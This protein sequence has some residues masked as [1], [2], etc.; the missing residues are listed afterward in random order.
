M[1]LRR[2]ALYFVIL[3]LI[4]VHARADDE[5]GAEDAGEDG[6]DEDGEDEEELSHRN[7][8]TWGRVFVDGGVQHRQFF[9]A[10]FGDDLPFEAMECAVAEPAIGCTAPKNDVNGKIVFVDRGK[11]TWA[12]KARGPGSMSAAGK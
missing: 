3:A 5:D 2:T 11:C 12:T 8:L 9:K 4:A 6:G 1:N 10:R 7:S